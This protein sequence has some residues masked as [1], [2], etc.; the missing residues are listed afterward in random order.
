MKA[1]NIVA[2]HSFPVWLP[3]TQTWM[4]NQVKYLPDAVESCDL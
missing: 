2:V 4:Y 3:R 1:D